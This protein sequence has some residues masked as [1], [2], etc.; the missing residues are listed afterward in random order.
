MVLVGLVSQNSTL[1]RAVIIVLK[2]SFMEASTTNGGDRNSSTCA[3]SEAEDLLN[4]ACR[5]GTEL[6]GDN[7]KW[8]YGPTY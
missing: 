3:R 8:K 1:L 7:C 5:L 6:A 4:T 2:E